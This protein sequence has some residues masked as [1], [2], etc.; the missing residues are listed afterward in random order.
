VLKDIFVEG[1][2]EGEEAEDTFI[3]E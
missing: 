2:T 3:E 1:W